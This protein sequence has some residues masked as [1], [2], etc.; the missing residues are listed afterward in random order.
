MK[1]WPGFKV[2]A[3]LRRSGLGSV[4]WRGVGVLVIGSAFCVRLR[5][6][7]P[8]EGPEPS[9]CGP[10]HWSRFRST[11]GARYADRRSCPLRLKIRRP[12]QRGWSPPQRRGVVRSPG[13]NTP[14]G[15]DPG[16]VTERLRTASTL[17]GGRTGPQIK[18]VRT[19]AKIGFR[20]QETAML[21]KIR[22]AS[23]LRVRCIDRDI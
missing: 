2:E 16:T 4:D 1:I 15:P 13:R 3:G 6:T 12:G 5:D 8:V 14:E 22:R 19:L 9:V 11:G 17:I 20:R 10:R 23:V 18:A 21:S 7:P